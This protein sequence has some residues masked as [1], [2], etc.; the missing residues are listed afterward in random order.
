MHRLNHRKIEELEKTLEKKELNM[1]L[2]SL[3]QGLFKLA[4]GKTLKRFFNITPKN[5]SFKANSKFSIICSHQRNAKCRS[6][7]HP[8]FIFLL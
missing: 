3:F 7:G 6:G 5:S 2:N 8:G 1:N 4:K